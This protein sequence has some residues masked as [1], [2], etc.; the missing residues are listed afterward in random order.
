MCDDGTV[1]CVGYHDGDDHDEAATVTTAELGTEAITEN[2]TEF[3]MFVHA[4]TTAPGWEEIVT[5]CDDGKFETNENGTIA[6]DE[7]ELGIETEAGTETN[8]EAAT[9]TKAELGIDA[10]TEN[11]TESG[12]FE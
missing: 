5:N 2:G 9:I 10:I 4:T 12:M 11:E 6:G 1:T 3:G 8:D 7:N